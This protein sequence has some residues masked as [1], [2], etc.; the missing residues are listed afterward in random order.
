M[1][2]N[3]NGNVNMMRKGLALEMIIMLIMLLVVAGVIISIFIQQFTSGNISDI[4]KE[5]LD[6]ARFTAKCEELCRS[7]NN[8]ASGASFCQHSAAV[9]KNGDSLISQQEIGVVDPL[10]DV[11]EDKIYCFQIY[12]CGKIRKEGNEQFQVQ[13]CRRYVCDALAQKLGS[14]QEA[15]AAVAE[16]LGPGACNLDFQSWYDKFIGSAP[17]TNPPI[18]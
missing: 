17:C 11:C 8:L 10:M 9:D 16:R 7:I 15:D 13:A 2:G 4:G 12:N 1:A 6:E 3:E 5:R 18:N 14:P